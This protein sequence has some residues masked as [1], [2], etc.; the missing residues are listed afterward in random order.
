MCA[1]E[2]KENI[3][4]QAAELL[5]GAIDMHVHANPHLAPWTHMLDAIELAK[6]AR[7]AGMKGMVI[8]D[9]AFPTTGTA[10][11]VNKIVPGFHVFGSILMNLICGGINPRAVSVAVNHGD[12][13]RLVYFPAGDTLHHVIARE[14][15]A[16]AGINLPTTRAQAISVV[17]N[18][19]LTPET[20]EVVKII[21]DADVC[22]VTGHLSPEETLIL[23]PRAI[24][25]GVKKIIIL[26]TMW[27]M[28]GFSPEHIRELKKYD[29]FFE[30][31]FGLC[32]PIMQID[33]RENTVDPRRMLKQMREIGVE[34]CI[35]TTDTGQA[36]S[37]P[38]LVAMKWFIAMLLKCG[39]TKD[40]IRQMVSKNPARLLDV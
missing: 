14:T 36:H 11:L 4:L 38:P 10:Y 2:Y 1:K 18:G 6:A 40:E 29:V 25:M 5:H 7:D 33:H 24:E 32:S 3:D 30:F 26:H 37:P 31:E 16:Y 20:S 35:M 28:I 8:K 12:G 9:M 27:Q 13:A 17:R 15:I 19:D 22:L 39:A 21:A 34:K 23:V